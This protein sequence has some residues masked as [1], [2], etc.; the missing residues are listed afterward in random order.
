MNEDKKLRHG[1][2]TKPQDA[3]LDDEAVEAV[4]GGL[5]RS[6]KD[7]AKKAWDFVEQVFDN[8]EDKEDQP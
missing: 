8:Q 4:T 2:F 3:A 5:K 6:S 7:L 1:V